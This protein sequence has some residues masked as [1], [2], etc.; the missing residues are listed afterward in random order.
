MRKGFNKLKARNINYRSYK[1]FSNEVF[2]E[3]FLGKLSQQTFLNN[4]Y[5]FEKFCN[6]TL[7]TLDKSAPRKAKHARGNQMLFMTKD[8]SK[9]IMKRSRLRNKYFENNNEENRKLYTKQRNYCVSLLR[10]TKKANYENLD[11]RKVSDKK[12]FMKTMKPSLSEKFNARERINFSENGK[13][14]KT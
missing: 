1:H 11:E 10:K 14:V 12:L 7:K 4:D 6:I 13:I 3:D 5:G 9:I 8:L 2:R